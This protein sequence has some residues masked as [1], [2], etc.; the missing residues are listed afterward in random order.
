MFVL[1]TFSVI[2]LYN[3]NSICYSLLW[4]FALCILLLLFVYC[5][6]LPY[7]RKR[8]PLYPMNTEPN[9]WSE[10]MK[11]LW[12]YQTEGYIQAK[13][14]ASY[15]NRYI[16][17]ELALFC[18]VCVKT[19]DSITFKYHFIVR[20]VKASAWKQNLKWISSNC[21]RIIE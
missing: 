2:H 10:T 19:I 9:W 13:Y 7:Y 8:V 21:P 12:L 6:T 1:S 14:V 15:K 11:A 4:Y 3:M 16:S 5:D 18:I 20:L 17:F